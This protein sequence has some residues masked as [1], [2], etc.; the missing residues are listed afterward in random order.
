MHKVLFCRTMNPMEFVFKRTAPL[1]F[2]PLYDWRRSIE[3][4]GD[5][6]QCGTDTALAVAIVD[7]EGVLKTW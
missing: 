3:V 5:T 7:S 1:A 2:V 6:S 4:V